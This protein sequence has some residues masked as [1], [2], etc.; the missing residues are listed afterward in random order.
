MFPDQHGLTNGVYLLFCSFFISCQKPPMG[1]SS[2]GSF[3]V[4][5][6]GSPI[7]FQLFR[8]RN[9]ALNRFFLLFLVTGMFLYWGGISM[10]HMVVCPIHLY[11]PQECR[12]PH[13]SPI[14]LCASACSQRLLH[15]VGVVGGCSPVGHLPYMLGHLP[16]YGACLP[17]CLTPSTHWLASLYI[18]MFLGISAC[19]MGNIPL[20]LGVGGVPHMLGIWGHQHHWV[21]ICFILYLLVVH[22]VSSIYH[23]YDYYFS[24]YG[25]VF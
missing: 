2:V 20:M 3:P 22:Y 10:P 1:I 17:I 13:M 14:L 21:S 4:W 9:L 24:G 16:L 8:C 5:S 6:G 19:D 12:C 18:C 11:A 15:V 7:I 23:S 25:G